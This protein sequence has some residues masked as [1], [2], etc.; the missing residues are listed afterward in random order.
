MGDPYTSVSVSGYNSNPPS[1]DGSQTEANRVKWSTIKSKLPDPLKTAIEAVN[2]NLLTAFAK[3]VGGAGITTTAI[4][5]T[6]QTSDHGKLVVATASGITI[7][8][9]DATSVG[10]P[11]VF[12]FSNDSSGDITLDGNGSQTIDGD[13]SVTVPSGKGGVIFTD[14]SNW[15]FAGRGWEISVLPPGHLFGLG[16]SNAADTA[17]DITVAAGRCR[18]SSNTVDLIISSALTKQIDASFVVGNNQGGRSSSGLSDT[19]WHVFVIG[20]A[21]GASADILFHDGVD[22]SAA[23][24]ADYLYYRRIGS[25]IRASSAIR[26]FIQVGDHFMWSPIIDETVGTAFDNTQRNYALTV[27]AGVSVL[28]DVYVWGAISGSVAS[29]VTGHPSITLASPTNS[30]GAPTA[31]VT[32]VSNVSNLPAQ[33][34]HLCRTNTSAQIAVRANGTCTGYDIYTYGYFDTRGREAA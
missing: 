2:A 3:V 16:L 11:F 13:A 26:Q 5:Y 27:P 23:L 32:G 7:T 12:A 22:P 31:A 10:A 15:R 21:L 25:I 18:D 34:R 14:G 28:A 24:P 30:A 4:S 29:F 6:V 1:D 19:T 9:P 8:T 17:N 20:K 33:S